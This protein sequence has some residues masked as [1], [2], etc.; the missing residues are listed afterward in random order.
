MTLQEINDLSR[1]ELI[2]IILAQAAQIAA[3]QKEIEVLRLKV[4]KN[5]P[6][7]P[8]NSKNSSQPPSQDQ[9]SGKM[10]NRPKRKHGPAHGHEKHERKLVAQPEHVVELKAKSCSGCQADLSTAAAELIDVNQ[11]TELPVAKAEVIEVRQYGV[12]CQQCGHVEIMQPS[13]GLEMGRT[14][15]AR[16]EATVT[17]YRQEQH[18]SYE[19]TE[20]S[21]LAL[22]GVEIS[23]GGIDQIMQRSGQQGLRAAT[24]I[25]CTVQHSAVVNSDE[26]GA[27]VD[28]QK[29]WEWVFCTLTAI[30]HVIK[31]TR[32]TDEIRSVMGNHQPEVWGSDCLP[33]QL[34]ATARLFQICLAHQL[35][36]LQAVVELYPLALWPR[37]MQALFRYAIHLR[38]QRDKL[39][40]NQYQ[41]QILRIEWL[42]NCLLDRTVTQ[43]E[44][45]KL[46]KRYLKHRQ[47]LFVFL[48]RND[49]PPTNNVS[50]RALRP[51]VI[52]R[53]VTGGFRSRWGAD[54]YAALASVIDTAAL[55]GVNAFDALQCLIG[56]PALPIP[57]IP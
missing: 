36:N 22:H 57:F 39:S 51:S 23:Q 50:E 27:R 13:E 29:A 2:Q 20:A 42:C 37:A 47:H 16:L 5:R 44:I 1:E 21:M 32:G 53:K 7:L 30:L 11:I 19:R 3:L 55:K 45:R 31:A 38:N 34:K 54:A 40:I 28:G 4:E 35:R 10:V 24:E 17:Y 6:K 25:Q 48:Y 33:A 26:T 52:H 12:T 18:M 43:P 14:F 46:Q 49:V 56:K 8:T 15:G 9:K 41:A